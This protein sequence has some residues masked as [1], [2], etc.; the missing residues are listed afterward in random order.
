MTRIKTALLGLVFLESLSPLSAAGNTVRAHAINGKAMTALASHV[1]VKYKDGHASQARSTLARRFQI[2]KHNHLDPLGIDS[3]A[4]PT[5][6]TVD[7]FIQMLKSDP[8][9]DFAEPD[10][11]YHA[12]AA[13]NDPLYSSQYYLQ[14]SKLKVE[15]AWTVTTGTASII[16]AVIDTGVTLTHPDLAANLWVNPSTS[17]ISGLH[18]A[19]ME[20][21]WN[22]N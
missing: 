1:L 9:I 15:T 2:H 16:V 8:D 12:F 18:G 6:E 21:D 7:S 5:G 10:G 20:I 13:P 3:M 17:A 19:V 4:I 14:S 22:E 11:I